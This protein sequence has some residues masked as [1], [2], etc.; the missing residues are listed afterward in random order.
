MEG[1]IYSSPLG[2]AVETAEIIHCFLNCDVERDDRLK[3]IN[4]GP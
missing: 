2:R 1:E 4:V 3:E